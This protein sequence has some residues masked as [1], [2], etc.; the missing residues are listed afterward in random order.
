MKC[1][2]D[3]YTRLAVR[4]YK[5]RWLLLVMVFSPFLLPFFPSSNLVYILFACVYVFS[6]FLF[7]VVLSYGPISH[8]QGSMIWEGWKSMAW[9]F[10]TVFAASVIWGVVSAVFQYAANS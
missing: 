7:N 2:I 8:F 10:L 9:L 4:F 5:W 6:F 1:I 3:F